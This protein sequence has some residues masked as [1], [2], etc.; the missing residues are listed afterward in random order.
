MLQPSFQ[1]TL[2]SILDVGDWTVK[3]SVFF[4]K[5]SFAEERNKLL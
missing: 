3:C 2:V 4:I 1:A 5:T